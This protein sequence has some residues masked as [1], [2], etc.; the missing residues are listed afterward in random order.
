MSKKTIAKIKEYP[1]SD[2]D[3]RAVLGNDIKIWNYPQ[4]K[5]L[6]NADEMFDKKGRAIL[7]F[8]NVSPTA[9]HWTCLINRPDSIEFF[10]SYGEAPDTTQKGGMSK[11]RLEM[12]DIERPDLTRLLRAS[13][14]PV[15]YNH[16]QFQKDS[17]NVASCGKHCC[18]RL[19]YEPYSL[20]KYNKIIES[21]GMS[22]DN[23]V[24][25]VIYNKIR[26]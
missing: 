15:F 12:L 9:G 18:V 19:L 23:F 1:L 7:L 11:G 5:A 26:K 8:P 20:E 13:G 6:Q 2:D 16:H 4:L 14:K 17:P 22:P 10:D 25:G 3:I 21:S 24:S